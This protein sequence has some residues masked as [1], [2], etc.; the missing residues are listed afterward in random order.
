MSQ[1]QDSWI[2]KI[3][4]KEYF[5]SLSHPRFL[6]LDGLI[7]LESHYTPEAFEQWKTV[8]EKNSSP[9]DLGKIENTINHVHLDDLTTDEG[10]QNEIGEY[11]RKIWIDT[12]VVQFPNYEFECQVKRFEQGWELVMQR[13]R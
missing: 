7:V 6:E 4:E 10:Q 1:I 13:R 12:A 11:L 5:N 8:L 9:A 3:T 2:S